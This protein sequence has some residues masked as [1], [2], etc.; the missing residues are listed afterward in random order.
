MIYEVRTYTINRGMMDSWL[1]VWSE[2]MVP[3]HK[4]YGMGIEG[5]WVPI[6]PPEFGSGYPSGN[7]PMRPKNE[8]IWVRSFAD[9]DDLKAKDGAWRSRPERLELGDRPSS[10]IAASDIRIVRSVYDPSA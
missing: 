5:A 9:L 4:K 7:Q 8:F 6:D 2:E 1:K 3:I 10:H